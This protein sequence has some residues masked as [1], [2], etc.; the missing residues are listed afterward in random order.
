MPESTT[1]TSATIVG[2]GKQR[3]R[4]HRLPS[5][6]IGGQ[7]RENEGNWNPLLDWEDVFAGN[8]G[9][10]RHGDYDVYDA[11]LG[12]HLKIEEAHTSEPLLVSETAWEG[13]GGLQPYGLWQAGGKFH[14][15]YGAYTPSGSRMCYAESEDGYTWSRPSLQQVQFEG[16]GE[17]NILANL[18]AG[19]P[20]FFVDPVAPPETRFKYMRQEGGSFDP[21]TGEKLSDEEWQRRLRAQ[22]YEGPNYKGPRTI[23]RHWITGF[24]SADGIHWEAIEG[25]LSDFPADGGIAPGYDPVG[26]QYY[27]YIRPTGVGRRAIALTTTSDFM[28]WPAC[29]LV[30]YPDPQDGPD[31]SFYGANHFVYPGRSDLFGMFLQVYHQI[32]DHIDN[33]LAISHDGVFW[34]RPERRAIILVGP[35][36]SGYEGMV[37]SWGGSLVQLPDGHWAT[38]HEC[39]SF[40]HNFR[41]DR[42][43]RDPFPARQA[44]QIRWARWRPHRLCGIE[45]ETEGRFTIQTIA[46]TQ[47]E[48]HLNYRCRPGGWV[49][50]EL[51]PAIPSR[52]NPDAQGIPGYSFAECDPLTGDAIDKVVTWNGNSDI[53]AAGDAMAIRIH[54][55]QAKIF[56]Y[57]C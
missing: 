15:I 9:M 19:G 53:S 3:F 18:P 44:S 17:N 21:D 12:I 34:N 14:M 24:T 2:I 22:D 56:A 13:G 57:Q 52:L 45:A 47:P 10:N 50:V 54:M 4:P 31:V 48:L 20:G 25:P 11:P 30:L 39:V 29:R 40:L 26:E 51:L 38:L 1:G 42:A 55:F 23:F 32:T 7:A 46:R 49:R 5:T 35:T 6:G 41:L 28:H 43:K 36:G 16:S 8:R 27:A 37:R 33:Q